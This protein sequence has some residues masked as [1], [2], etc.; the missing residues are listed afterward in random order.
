MEKDRKYT[1]VH[2]ISN[3][4]PLTE[5]W[6]YNQIKY[7]IKFKPTILARTTSNSNIFPVDVLHSLMKR[8]KL[9]YILNI[10]AFKLIGFIPFFYSICKKENA[11]IL[12]IHFG[13]HGI[14]FL[15]LKRVL[16]IP[17]I[18]SFYGTDVFMF[19]F[20]KK[21]NLKKLQNLFFHADA[22]LVLGPYMKKS[23]INLGCP[24]EKII[25][26][27]LGVVTQKIEFR[28]RI[29]SENK[30]LKFLLASSFVEKKGIDICLKAL[31]KVNHKIDFKV[32][33]IGDGILKNEI[34][35]LINQL[36]LQD[37]V[38]LHGYQKYEFM[39][40]LAY[41]CDIFLQA[42]KTSSKNDKEGTPMVLVDMMATGLP[43]IS[44][45]HSDIPEIVEEGI[46][47]FLAEENDVDSFARK[48]MEFWSKREQIPKLSK[49]CRI[50]IENDFDAQKQSIILEKI[51]C[52]ILNT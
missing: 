44:T 46:T 24:A 34:I 9:F 52:S 21:G 39:L 41:S 13:Y 51:Y 26:H 5:I 14:K 2:Y 43:V 28:E 38:T 23:L 18:C 3:F 36:N 32:E 40:N 7:L 30:P 6:I 50:K 29:I 35:Q 15:R 47:G 19:P 12:H 45:R 49:N 4:L 33:I 11:K 8:G 42:S 25:I 16:K 20:Q 10:V 1:C 37:K 31:V 22:I 27:H 17:M 48:I